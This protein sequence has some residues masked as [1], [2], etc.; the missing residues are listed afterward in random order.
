MHHRLMMGQAARRGRVL[1]VQESALRY[2]GATIARAAT[3]TA[4]VQVR[5]QPTSTVTPTVTSTDV[6]SE[7]AAPAMSTARVDREVEVRRAAGEGRAL[8]IVDH[9]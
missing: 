7:S 6:D 8:E 1:Y 3:C 2:S 4:E 5:E 9:T